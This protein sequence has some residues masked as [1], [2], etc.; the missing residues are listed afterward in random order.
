LSSA[1]ENIE[2]ACGSSADRANDYVAA[3]K[4]FE[5]YLRGDDRTND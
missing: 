1:I 2:N 4:I 5:A 3:A